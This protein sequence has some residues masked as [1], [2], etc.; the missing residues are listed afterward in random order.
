MAAKQNGDSYPNKFYGSCAESAANTLTFTEIQTNVSIMEKVAWVLHRLEWFID[1]TAWGALVATDDRISAALCSTN[2]LTELS[3]GDAGVIDFADFGIKLLS[4]VG[5]QITLGPNAT[6]DFTSLP[7]GG[8]LIAPRPLYVAVQG[9][10]L[11][12]AQTVRVRG[13]YTQKVLSADEY[14]ELVDFYRI[15]K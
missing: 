1:A 2:S 12:A 6:R 11:A 10:S 8:L 4:S 5:F 14:I 9:V 13:Y 7:G 15:V 3:L